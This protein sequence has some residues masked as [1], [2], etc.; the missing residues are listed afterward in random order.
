M[1]CTTSALTGRYG[2]FEV[3]DQMVARTQQWAVNP[4][5]ATKSEWGD[6][7]TAGYTARMA[8]RKDAS[9]TAEG[10]Y[11]IDEEQFDI[12]QPGDK[13]QTTLWMRIP[14]GV[15]TGLYWDFPC[16]LCD[17]FAMSVNIDTQEVIGWTSG[18]GADGKF[19]YPGMADAP[20]R[21]PPDDSDSD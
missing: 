14:V 4:K 8:G 6:S 16:A 21:T 12:F 5:L 10:K 18:W 20:V 17:D 19:Y 11:D 7:D 15:L 3:D 1:S 2:K 13:L 9:F